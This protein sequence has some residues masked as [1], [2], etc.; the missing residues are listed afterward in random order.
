MADKSKN[1]GNRELP[2][3]LE[4]DFVIC[5]NT[6]NRKGWR[7][8]VDGI[9]LTAFNANPICCF[10]HEVRD[11]PVGRWK[12]VR[13][14]GEK[15][16]GTVEF[17]RNDEFAVKLYWKYAD[18]FMKACSLWID[19]IEE[20]DNASLL[21]P[22][23]RYGTVTKSELLEI[24]LVT[25]PGQ[26]NAIVLSNNNELKLS[27]SGSEYHLK[28]IKLNENPETM[29]KE[30]KN[31]VDELSKQLSTEKERNATLL[32]KLHQK[33]GVVADGEVE[34]LKKLAITDPDSVEKMLE[35]RPEPTPE[36]VEE[37]SKTEETEKKEQERK[38]LSAKLENFGKDGSGKS[39]NGRDGWNYLE[40]FKKD[41]QGLELMAKNEPEKFKK[42]EMD[43]AQE[44]K[45][46][47]LKAE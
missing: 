7:L 32:I 6:L 28:E 44:S 4:F 29:D 40:W 17:D 31:N 22:G 19:P 30:E 24:S 34:H 41:P 12:N 46:M 39:A 21:V 3:K 2:E 42:L 10:R 47:H 8:L 26:K 25:L 5:D 13:V 1:S 11:I 18:G 16:L 43:F 38:E 23:Q 33:R 20:S 37:T 36:K 27:H 14:E 15:L 45:A 9:D 35:A